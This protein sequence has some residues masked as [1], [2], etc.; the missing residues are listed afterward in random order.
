MK[1]MICDILI[2]MAVLIIAVG[3]AIWSTAEHWKYN[4]RSRKNTMN[5]PSDKYHIL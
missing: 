3:V 2:L 4:R 1:D 5:S